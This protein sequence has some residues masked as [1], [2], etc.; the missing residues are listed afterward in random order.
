MMR[1]VAA[2]IVAALTA[3]AAY[4]QTSVVDGRARLSTSA[5]AYFTPEGVRKAATKEDMRAA[6]V[7]LMADAKIDASESD[8][9][10]EVAEQAPFALSVA[11]VTGELAVPAASADAAALARLLITPPSMNTLWHGDPDRTEQL[12]ELSRWGPAAHARVSTFF[13]NK[14]YE[15]WT[16]SNVLNAYGP[17]VDALGREWNAVKA[18]PDPESARAGKQLLIDGCEFTKQKTTDEGKVAP[19]GYLCGWMAGSL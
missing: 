15:A 9:L 12:V 4:A 18:L 13:G 10:K 5:G 2:G 17:F 1:V 7:A 11:D 8:F 19:P 6:I 3:S 14:L 16:Q